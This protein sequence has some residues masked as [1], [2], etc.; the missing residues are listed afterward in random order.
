[1]NP[2]EIKGLCK[3]FGSTQV[4]RDLDLTIRPHEVVA[5]IGGS[6]CGK[7]TLFR[8]ME[9]L[10]TPDAGSILIDGQEITA[11]GANVDKI[12][13]SMGM[14][15]QS[16]NL[17]THMSVMDNLCLA[18]VRLLGMSRADA[19][20]KAEDLLDQVGLHGRGK[21]MPAQLSG[22]QKQ[23][24]AIARCLMMEPKI[25]LFDE[26]TSALD[27]GMIG[28]VLA[29]MRMLTKRG[30]T[31]VIVTHEMKF[32]REIASRVLFMADQGIYEDGPPE[33]IFEHPQ[34]EK[35]ISFIRKLK[36]FNY[37][38]DSPQFDLMALQGGIQR[39]AERY[40]LSN[41]I[42]YRLQLCTEELLHELLSVRSGGKIEIDISVEFSEEDA[43]TMLLCGDTGSR[44]N[45]FDKPSSDD[46]LGVTI[47]KNTSRN[48]QHHYE[49]GRNLLTIEM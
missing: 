5:I 48:Y 46:S 29:T 31:M 3:S 11:K 18:P 2:I 21:Q 6:G 27:P 43:R 39:F 34:K 20:K 16:F 41:R 40:G 19:E 22:G 32:A 35:T 17:F 23:R 28:E 26:P 45:P 42:A 47:I 38:I 44:Y 24:V 15:Y 12:R 30:M 33:Q 7:T 36:H 37:H 1:M 14:V 9:L 25:M 49:D 4:L 13:R 8:C 10:E